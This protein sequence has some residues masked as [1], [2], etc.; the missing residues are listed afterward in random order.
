MFLGTV[1]ACS[2]DGHVVQW[3]AVPAPHGGFRADKVVSEIDCANFEEDRYMGFDVAMAKLRQGPYLHGVDF[4]SPETFAMNADG[5]SNPHG[6]MARFL[7]VCETMLDIAKESGVNDKGIPKR[8]MVV[9][10]HVGEGFPSFDKSTIYTT[11]EQEPAY[12]PFPAGEPASL[13]EIREAWQSFSDKR[14]G[15]I[16]AKYTDLCAKANLPH[17]FDARGWAPIHTLGA[18]EE[19]SCAARYNAADVAKMGSA[20]FNAG[21]QVNGGTRCYPGEPLHYEGGRQN[22]DAL[23]QMVRH[24]HETLDGEGFN[25]YIRIQFGHVTHTTVAQARVMKDL[26]VM[27]DADLSSNLATG[28]L[29]WAGEASSALFTSF[30]DQNTYAHTGRQAIMAPDSGVAE[31]FQRHGLLKLLLAG[32]SVTL[33]TD[34]IGVEHS[35]FQQDYHVADAVI[36]KYLTEGPGCNDKLK[37]GQTASPLCAEIG[38]LWGIFGDTGVRVTDL[39]QNQ[40]EQW[41]WIRAAEDSADMAAGT[42]GL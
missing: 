2:N 8:R 3:K 6:A 24:V 32:I 9:H 31:V 21:A 38:Q 22:I 10:V 17:V 16:P 7:K 27:A 35:G 41:E 12:T 37:A 18:G 30:G 15:M 11:G 28:A 20:A 5:E 33:G 26:R 19:S 36:Q 42:L 1:L 14:F 39:L 23:L 29:H 4:A 25:D 34:S 40:H 13:H